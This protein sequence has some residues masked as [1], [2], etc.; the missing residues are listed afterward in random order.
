MMNKNIKRLSFALLA[1]GLSAPAFSN[2]AVSIPSQHGGF[3]VG[4]D[5]LYLRNNEITPISNSSY[6]LGTSAQIGYL[7]SG[8]GNDL[9]VGY[10]YLRADN[11]D[12]MDIDTVDLE[13]GQR[14]TAGAFDLRLFTGLRYTHLDYKLNTDDALVSSNFH[15]IGPRF[16][17]DARYQISNNI[18]F[19]T[20]LN[21]ALLAAT[22]TT[23]YKDKDTLVS[24][25][26]DGIIPNVAAKVGMDYTYV[27]PSD[28]SA[29]VFEV[30]YQADHAFNVIDKSIDVSFDGP[31][32]NVKY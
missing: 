7:F 27:V 15:G 18:G 8:T 31:Y 5:A 28:K 20:H 2:N 3:K 24:Q 4:V 11:N 17:V 6:D 22:S 30:G 32:L 16:G 19:D 10:T 21:S 12:S 26:I 29:V 13:G 14:L 1:L 23:R 25:S 9:T